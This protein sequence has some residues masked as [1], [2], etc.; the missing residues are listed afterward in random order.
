ME[1]VHITSLSFESERVLAALRVYPVD[2]VYLIAEGVAVSGLQEARNP[3]ESLRNV[4]DA[5][6]VACEAEFI[7]LYQKVRDLAELERRAGNNVV[8]NISAGSKLFAAAAAVACQEL[9]LEMYYVV[10]S[11]Y[12]VSPQYTAGVREIQR[13]QTPKSPLRL[14]VDS[15][16]CFVAMPFSAHLQSTFEDAIHPVVEEAGLRCVRADDFFAPRPIMDDIWGSLETA[17]LVIAD[18]TER[19]ANVFYEAGLAHALGRDVILLAQ[20]IDDVPFDLRHVRC[21][22]YTDTYRGIIKLRKDLAAAISAALERTKSR[23]ALE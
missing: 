2:R 7:A 6:V 15:T 14:E 5:V 3:V 13:I 12:H 11:H 18:L 4:M 17:R 16:L 23:R 9:R 20:A 10:P 1:Q 21:L 22:L 8:V 19:N